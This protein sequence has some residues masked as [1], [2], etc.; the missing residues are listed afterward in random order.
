MS[1]SLEQRTVILVIRYD[2]AAGPNSSVSGNTFDRLQARR[3]ALPLPRGCER[4]DGRAE[5]PARDESQEHWQVA[6]R[7]LL[8]D[9]CSH[10]VSGVP[11]E[12]NRRLAITPHR[13]VRAKAAP[14]NRGIRAWARR[15]LTGMAQRG[16]LRVPAHDFRGPAPPDFGL[17]LRP[18]GRQGSIL[19]GNLEPQ[20]EPRPN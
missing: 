17:Q 20:T 13:P 5:V 3:G 9:E 19:V 16:D 6:A 8:L 7:L 10:A 15:S 2:R 18:R 11:G 4:L 1:F 12:C 14:E